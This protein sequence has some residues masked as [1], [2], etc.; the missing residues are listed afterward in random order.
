MNKNILVVVF[1]IIIFFLG[2]F[3]GILVRKSTY[4]EVKAEFQSQIID[5]QN[6]LQQADFL[7]RKLKVI[8][9]T[10]EQKNELIKEKNQIIMDREA[11]I[12][13]LGRKISTTS[14][15][16]TIKDLAK[17]IEE[18]NRELKIIR[19]EYKQLAEDAEKAR[20]ELEQANKTLEKQNKKILDLNKKLAESGTRDVK[21]VQEEITTVRKQISAYEAA[22]K[23]EYKADNYNGKNKRLRQDQNYYSAYYHYAVAQSAYDMKRVYNKIKS[24]E[25]KEKIDK[26]VLDIPKNN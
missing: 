23:F 4:D 2:F 10:V 20:T 19:V 15:P 13:E 25:I 24:K 1:F 17:Q 8:F 9:Q 16:S 26:G 7:N 11:E 14:N 22:S 6:D 21:K 3:S 18:K 12:E 5:L